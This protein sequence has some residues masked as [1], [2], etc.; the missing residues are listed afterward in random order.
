MAQKMIFISSKDYLYRE[1]LIDYVFVPGFAPSQRR[2]NVINLENSI[3]K[4][5][6]NLKVLEVSTKS[7]NPLGISLSAFNLILDGKHLESIFQ[8]SKCFEDGSHFDFLKDQ[9]PSF[10]K[11]YI[12]ENGKGRLKKF[13]Y[14][15]VEFPLFPETFFYDYIY[16]KALYQNKELSDQLANFDIFTDIEFNHM[17]SINCQARSCAIYAYLLKNNIV[18]DV[19]S[20]P[21]N[22]KAL[23]KE[24]KIFGQL[25]LFDLA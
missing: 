8:S 12:R 15:G 13:V 11:K 9:K 22:L 2:K 6:P 24:K 18:E 4:E 1:K 14:D 17:K 19:V 7:N 16:I 21:E 23:Y 3:K 10:A 25:S 20:N 5:F